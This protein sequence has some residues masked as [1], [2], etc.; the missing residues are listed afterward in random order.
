MAQFNLG[1][2]GCQSTLQGAARRPMAVL[3]CGGTRI[4]RPVHHA[5][6]K[7]CDLED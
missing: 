3:R 4:E 6:G 7:S 2:V 1:P 5:G